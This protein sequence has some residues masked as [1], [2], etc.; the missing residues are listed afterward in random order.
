MLAT[1]RVHAPARNSFGSLVKIITYV[2]RNAAKDSVSAEFAMGNTKP[3]RL[4]QG[5]TFQ[6]SFLGGLRIR[7]A[8]QIR[9]ICRPRRR[10]LA[11]RA[12]HESHFDICRVT[13]VPLVHRAKCTRDLSRL[14]IP[15]GGAQ[16][17][18]TDAPRRDDGDGF[19]DRSRV[20]AI[21]KSILCDHREIIRTAL[22][23]ARLRK[24]LNARASASDEGRERGP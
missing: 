4:F 13:N 12:C 3:E 17:K 6:V 23:F 7:F 15:L 18:E 10:Q 22:R 16:K 11:P 24:K 2:H 5:P 8:T 14:H 21:V 9:S 19:A 20:R 1:A